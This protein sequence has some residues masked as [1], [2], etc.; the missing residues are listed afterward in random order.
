MRWMYAMATWV[1]AW[2]GLVWFLTGCGAAL[3]SGDNL[4][5]TF[6]PDMDDLTIAEQ[7][8]S[9]VFG[10]DEGGAFLIEPCVVG[11]IQLFGW[12]TSWLG[13]V[14]PGHW[15]RFRVETLECGAQPKPDPALGGQNPASHTGSGR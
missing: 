7:P 11:E 1:G 12:H 5:L 9:I 3:D 14:D 6:E 4:L 2:A 10:N 8:Y 13:S 15:N